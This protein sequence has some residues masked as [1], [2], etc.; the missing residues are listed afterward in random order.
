MSA[1]IEPFDYST[2]FRRNLGF[3]TESQQEK[4]R[5]ARVAV[6]G[7]GGTGGAQVHALA[8]LGMG[9]FTLADPD[10]FELVNFNRQSGATVPNLGRLK[11]DVARE[12]VLSINPDADVAVFNQGITADNIDAFLQGVDVVVDSLDFYCFEERFMLYGKARAKGLWVLTAPPL[13]FGFT[14]LVFDPNGMSF[15][16]Y[17]GFHSGMSE[18]ERVVALIAGIAPQPFMLRYLDREQPAMAERRLPSVGVA[19]F[20]IAGVIA[21]EII[22]VL[23]GKGSTIA[24]P[25]IYQF[26]ALLRRFRRRTYVWGMRGPIQRLKRVLLNRML[27]E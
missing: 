1:S 14:L 23:T 7:L 9:R 19:P 13:G 6:A 8:R 24:V 11:T 22:Q 12:T 18:R 2:A 3:I 5:N 16:D 26:D 10:V 25:T 20:M 15:E 21:T 4:L 17:F 27:P